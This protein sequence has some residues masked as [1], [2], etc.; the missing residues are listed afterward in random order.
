ML[1]GSPE[2]PTFPLNTMADFAGG[3]MMCVLGVLLALFERATKS[4]KGQV[5]DIDMV[6][7]TKSFTFKF[8]A[9]PRSTGLRNSV[10][11]VILSRTCEARFWF[12]IVLPTPWPEFVG[13][14]CTVLRRLH[15]L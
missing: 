15:L 8:G 13:W 11:L 10:P 4:G 12:T 14:W 1:P 6:R 2:K 3:G 5:V 9:D 7:G